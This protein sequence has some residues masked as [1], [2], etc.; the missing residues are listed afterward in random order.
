MVRNM[1]KKE[2]VNFLEPF[3]DD[4]NIVVRGENKNIMAPITY[5]LKYL[6][7]TDDRSAIV[8]IQMHSATAVNTGVS[9]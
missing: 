1:T 4:I 9:A 8:V 7:F 5:E 2:L 3:D 6:P